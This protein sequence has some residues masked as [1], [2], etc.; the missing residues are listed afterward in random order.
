LLHGSHKP[1]E[2]AAM[3]DAMRWCQRDPSAA[4]SVPYRGVREH[5][6]RGWLVHSSLLAACCLTREDDDLEPADEPPCCLPWHAKQRVPASTLDWLQAAESTMEAPPASLFRRAVSKASPRR[7]P[8]VDAC[9]S[10]G[11]SSDVEPAPEPTAPASLS[12]AAAAAVAVDRSTSGPPRAPTAGGVSALLPGEDAGVLCAGTAH[13]LQGAAEEPW[14]GTE[15]RSDENHGTSTTT[16]TDGA[17][18]KLSDVDGWELLHS[19]LDDLTSAVMHL[20]QRHDSAEGTDKDGALVCVPTAPEEAGREST[21]AVS[22]PWA[23]P[24][25]V[26][27]GLDV[28]LQY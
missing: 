5:V 16:E 19:K 12:S 25:T 20:L 10:R 2:R 3:Q 8:S 11:V 28:M 1:P 22:A 27:Y 9:C 18:S 24:S 7:P 23:Q 4:K 6:A 15:G 17:S 21:R 14:S 26:G 13:L